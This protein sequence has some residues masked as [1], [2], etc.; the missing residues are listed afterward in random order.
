MAKNRTSTDLLERLREL[1]YRFPGTEEKLT[2]G[3]PAFHVRGK[4]FASFADHE[5]YDG[6]VSAMV[7]MERADQQRL[8]R[9]DP[10]R[11]YVPKYIGVK[12]WTGVVLN[13]PSTDW[14]ELAI[15]I[16]E[17]WSSV[18]PKSVANG[19]ARPPPPPPRLPTTDPEVAAA[20][21]ARLEKIC[22]KLPETKV[23]REGSHASFLVADKTYAYFLD[24]HHG[25][26]EIAVA[27]RVPKP[28][29]AALAKKDPK[30]FYLPAYIH[31]RGWVAMRLTGKVDWKEVAERLEASYR[32]AAPKRLAGAV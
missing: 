10:E 18:V 12:G 6:R 1:C 2:Y 32:S 3:A 22:G 29:H 21:L 11:F 5:E 25:D 19:P 13:R 8:V 24:N 20:A 26:E 28:K 7:K 14:I 27:V 9:Q 15:L 4:L 16:E 23:E 17:A 31:A 30:R